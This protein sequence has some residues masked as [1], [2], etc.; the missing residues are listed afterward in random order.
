M[1]R[2]CGRVL[3]K[4][5]ICECDAHLIYSPRKHVNASS[6]SI[7]R[8][9]IRQT[10]L[11]LGQQQQ[12]QNVQKH[13]R[14]IKIHTKRI[15]KN[16]KEEILKMLM[17]SK[18]Q[19]INPTENIFFEIVQIKLIIIYQQK[20]ACGAHATQQRLTKQTFNIKR[21]NINIW[22]PGSVNYLNYFL[23]WSYFCFCQSTTTVVN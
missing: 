9:S 17:R 5:S 12:Q 2:Q 7:I 13:F 3:F 16:S 21:K 18:P 14:L 11:Y 1:F 8:K 20:W 22:Q 6:F 4:R 23:C 19:K 15:K 10:N